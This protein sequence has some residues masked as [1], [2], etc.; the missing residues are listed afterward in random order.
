ME[1]DI[2]EEDEKFINKLAKTNAIKALSE[3][4][5][6]NMT[7]DEFSQL[8][9]TYM[10][11]KAKKKGSSEAFSYFL[12]DELLAVIKTAIKSAPTF[13]PEMMTDLEFMKMGAELFGERFDLNT[14]FEE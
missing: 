11:F 6:E 8:I 4:I 3:A 13:I 7:K 2:T 10:L 1:K 12:K 5:K 14:L 9:A